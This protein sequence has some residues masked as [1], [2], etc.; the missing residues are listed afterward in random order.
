[1]SGENAKAYKGSACPLTTCRSH[2][3]PCRIDTKALPLKRA[4]LVFSAV[5]IT[6]CQFHEVQ[7]LPVFS[8]LI[9]VSESRSDWESPDCLP[10]NDDK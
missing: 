10:Y 5:Q 6:I 9:G 3:C 1:M 7:I 2:W 4:E 8:I